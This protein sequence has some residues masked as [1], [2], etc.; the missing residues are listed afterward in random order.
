MSSDKITIEITKKDKVYLSIILVLVCAIVCLAI[1]LPR[2]YKVV[3][4]EKPVYEKVYQKVYKT[5]QVYII[6]PSNSLYDEVTNSYTDANQNIYVSGVT[7]NYVDTG[8]LIESKVSLM[9][10]NQGI[11]EKKE[12]KLSNT[13]QELL[14]KGSNNYDFGVDIEINYNLMANIKNLFIAQVGEV[15][16]NVLDS[17]LFEFSFN[18]AKVNIIVNYLSE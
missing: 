17:Y 18:Q 7:N 16:V 15:N 8:V 10:D 14:V 11:E 5:E 2:P 1:C 3:E 13:L 4:V 6:S 9:V 12:I